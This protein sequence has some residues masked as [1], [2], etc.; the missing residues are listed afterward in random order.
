MGRRGGLTG[1]VLVLA[2]ATQYSGQHLLRLEQGTAGHVVLVV[3]AVAFGVGATLLADLAGRTPLSVAGAVVAV[4]GQSLTLAVLAADLDV[5]D[6]AVGTIRALDTWDVLS[7]VGL[8]VVLLGLRRSRPDLGL[9][10]SAALVGLAVPALDGMVLLAAVAVVV[11]FV[12]LALALTGRLGSQGGVHPL[13]RWGVVVLYLA[14]AWVS[15]PRAALAVV[16][17]VVSAASASPGSL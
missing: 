9:G 14:F 8:V 16:V 7:V 12:V 4:V 13:L 5:L 11:G 1:L 10:A 2:A 3:S 17:L 15:W 6:L